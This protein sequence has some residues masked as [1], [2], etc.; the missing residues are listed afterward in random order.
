MYLGCHLSFSKGYENLGIDANKIGAN[1]FQFF[2]RSPQ[3]GKARAL[4]VEDIERLNLILKEHNFDHILAHA[5]YTLN[6]A[7]SKEYVRTYA[8]EVMRDDIY[9][10]SYIDNALY[11]FH[12]GSHV[13]QG[14]EAGWKY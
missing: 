8:E 14:V 9:R 1:T 10:M 4:D 13:G 2:T 5:P 6:A 12:P 3:G 7:S 11:N